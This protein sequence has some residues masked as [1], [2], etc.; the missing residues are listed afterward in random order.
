MPVSKLIQVIKDVASLHRVFSVDKDEELP[1]QLKPLKLHQNVKSLKDTS[2]F[3]KALMYQTEET[4]GKI[5][6]YWYLLFGSE[7][8]HSFLRE[9]TH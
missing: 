1:F 5:T 4:T 3:L 7:C 2:K 6:I 9:V 8:T